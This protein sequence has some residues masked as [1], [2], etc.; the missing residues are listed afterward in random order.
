M[1]IFKIGLPIV[2]IG[3]LTLSF[4]LKW[5]APDRFDIYT[6]LFGL[7]YLVPFLIFMPSI[8]KLY[9]ADKESR[10]VYVSFFAAGINLILS[11][12]LI[13]ILGLNGALL[14]SAFSQI[15]MLIIFKLIINTSLSKMTNLHGWEER[16]H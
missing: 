4:F 3:L 16:N 11:W 14:G 12:L 2:L 1:L 6:Y 13:P 10:V 9:K 15:F 5:L 7:L 8:F